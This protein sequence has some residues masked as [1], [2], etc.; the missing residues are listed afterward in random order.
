MA[1]ER[2]QRDRGGGGARYSVPPAVPA[3]RCAVL[4]P[5]AQDEGVDFNFSSAKINPVKRTLKDIPIETA[6]PNATTRRAMREAASGRGLER[7]G[8]TRKEIREWNENFARRVLGN[9]SHAKV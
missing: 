4:R 8:S 7:V 9:K 2:S 6:I 3:G 5:G 1:H